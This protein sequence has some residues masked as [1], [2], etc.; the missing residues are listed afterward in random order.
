MLICSSSPFPPQ[1]TSCAFW[2]PSAR[3]AASAKRALA[4]WWDGHGRW[5]LGRQPT[6]SFVATGLREDCARVDTVVA[7]ITLDCLPT[8]RIGQAA[9]RAAAFGIRWLFVGWRLRP[10]RAIRRMALVV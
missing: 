6:D 5:L 8:G 3:P 4:R 1:V 10:A 9:E 7:C 2:S